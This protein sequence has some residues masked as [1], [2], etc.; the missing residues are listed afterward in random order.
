MTA[1]L[2][3]PSPEDPMACEVEPLLEEVEREELLREEEVCPPNRVVAARNAEEL[4]VGLPIPPL[5]WAEDA[6]AEPESPD[7]A[8]D[9]VDDESDE[10]SDAPPP[11]ACDADDDEELLTFRIAAV[12]TVGMRTSVFPRKPPRVLGALSAA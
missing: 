10:E 4:D 11:E 8:S 1:L 9:A 2:V 7:E 12:L 6:P 3:D 5:D